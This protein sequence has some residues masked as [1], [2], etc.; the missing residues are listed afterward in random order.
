M[1]VVEEEVEKQVIRGNDF[2]LYKVYRDAY[3]HQN[4]LIKYLV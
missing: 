4:E 2:Y 1:E 3:C